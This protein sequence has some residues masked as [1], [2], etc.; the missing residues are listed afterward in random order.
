MPNTFNIIYNAIDI[1]FNKKNKLPR[2]NNDLMV[3]ILC[4]KVF[5]STT[6]AASSIVSFVVPFVFRHLPTCFLMDVWFSNWAK[7]ITD[8]SVLMVV[9]VD[10]VDVDADED[11][12]SF[13]PR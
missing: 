2:L 3:W 1:H 9:G 7:F 13:T 6:T 10:G 8:G 11:S 12:I 5:V 4:I